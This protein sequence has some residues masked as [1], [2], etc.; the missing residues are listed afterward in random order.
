MP[1][2][3]GQVIF[4]QYEEPDKITVFMDTVDKA[5]ALLSRRPN[6]VNLLGKRSIEQVLVAREIF[7]AVELRAKDTIFTQTYRLQLWK[8]GPLKNE[9]GVA[10]LGPD[11]GHGICPHTAGA[12]FLPLPV[13]CV[14]CIAVR[15]TGRQRPVPQ[16][17]P[18]VQPAF[19]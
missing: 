10:C 7:H 1:N 6:L 11:C 15:C 13:R 5:N 8:L 3:G 14:L 12:G 16:Y 17:L 4:A 9:S 2:G 19:D 18:P